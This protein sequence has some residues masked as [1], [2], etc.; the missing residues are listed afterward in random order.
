ME[1]IALALRRHYHCE[2]AREVLQKNGLEY[3]VFEITEAAASFRPLHRAVEQGVEIFITGDVYSDQL[4]QRLNVPV[5]TIRRSSLPFADCIRDALRLADRI[6]L[7]WRAR[8]SDSAERACRSFGTAATFFSYRKTEELPELCRRLKAAGFRVLVGAGTLNAHAAA[9]DLTVVNVP[10]DETDIL[11]AV[12]IAEHNLYYIGEMH[13]RMEVLNSIQDNISEGIL[14]LDASGNV[15]VFN[16][17]SLALLKTGRSSLTGQSVSRLLP[18]FPELKSL[19]SSYTAF[20][21]RICLVEGRALAVSGR[22]VFVRRAFRYALLTLTPAADVQQSEEQIRRQLA[23]TRGGQQVLF[24]NLV[25]AGRSMSACV[26][27]AQR[28]ARTEYPVLLSGAPGTGKETFARCIHS[29]GPRK[30]E[31]FLAL[32]CASLPE[33]ALDR[34]LFGYLSETGNPGG[35]RVMPGAL[36]RAH[37]GTLYLAGIAALPLRLQGRLVAAIE[38]GSVLPQGS[39]VPMPVDVRLIAGTDRPLETQVSTGQFRPDL[40]YR[41]SVLKLALPTL[42]EQKEDFLTAAALHFFRRARPDGKQPEQAPAAEVTELLKSRPWPGNLDEL[43]TVVTR[44]AALSRQDTLEP[45]ALTE[46]LLMEDAPSA[47]GAFPTAG[48]LP[49]YGAVPA[50]GG[51]TT[52][53]AAPA[54]GGPAAP[55]VAPGSAGSAG[56]SAPSGHKK[57]AP[58]SGGEALKELQAALIRAALQKNRFNRAKTAAELGIS[59]STLYRRMKQLSLI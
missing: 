59:P 18:E 3:P 36:S 50:P 13:D 54:P 23:A 55:A 33:D 28:I 15:Q 5:V 47:A 48:A 53:A 56:S 45:P 16:R 32:D 43:R 27:L 19:L 34:A 44:A 20:T 57:S 7:V 4:M 12:R 26:R 38:R 58:T 30:D 6:A 21:N 37:G 40:F 17:P 8:D 46:A 25:R 22:P 2:R 11:S 31:V 29:G 9:C 10:Y 39:T 42:S 52:P 14:L 41:L 35:G 24:R 49:A 1:K 51:L